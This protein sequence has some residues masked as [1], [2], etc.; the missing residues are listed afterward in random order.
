M[1][2]GET[3]NL[4]VDYELYRKLYEIGQV[5]GEHP[6]DVA[7][8]ILRAGTEARVEAMVKEAEAERRHLEAEL[9]ALNARLAGLNGPSK[10]PRR[11]VEPPS[12]QD[13]PLPPLSPADLREAVRGILGSDRDRTWT[14]GDV[15]MQ[16]AAMGYDVSNDG[17]E[18]PGATGGYFYRQVNAALR[19]LCREQQAR[20]PVRGEYA[21]RKRPPAPRS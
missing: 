1:K 20:N 11:P 21:Y 17:A 13:W 8:T 15:V 5:T 9:T 7:M 19:A 4:V 6:A 16:L 18:A 14:T 3:L 10:A 12:P 2:V